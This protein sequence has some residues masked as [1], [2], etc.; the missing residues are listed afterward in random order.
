MAA[1][2]VPIMK[3]VLSHLQENADRIYSAEQ[4][5]AEL[6]LPNHTVGSV[7]TMLRK[8]YDAK[9]FPQ[10]EVVR[11]GLYRWNSTVKDNGSNPGDAVIYSLIRNDGDKQLVTDEA[12]VVWKMYKMSDY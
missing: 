12:G 7:R 2:R 11:R 4:L 3:P 5:V 9:T 1:K 10:L 6:G 8:V